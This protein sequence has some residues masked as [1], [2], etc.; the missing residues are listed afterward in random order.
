MQDPDVVAHAEQPVHGEQ[1]EDVP[2][3]EYVN[4]SHS[5]HLLLTNLYPALQLAQD[6]VVETQEEQPVHS[7][8]EEDVPPDEYVNDPH[9]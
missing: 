1:E 6:P 4:D 9:A 3:V 8:H 2:P 7:K 5:I